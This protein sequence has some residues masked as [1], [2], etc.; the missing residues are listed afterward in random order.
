MRKAAE[1]PAASAANGA[2]E[3]PAAES[4]PAPAALAAAVRNE[5]APARRVRKSNGAAKP[6]ARRS[7][8]GAAS[9]KAAQAAVEQEARQPSISAEPI[10]DPAAHQ[11]EIEKLAYAIWEARGASNGSPDEDWFRAEN[12]L[13]RRVQKARS[14]VA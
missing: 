9:R 5:A 3:L 10:F 7:A 12:E 4:V 11:E 14:A 6:A 13:R 1:N 2:A 8:P